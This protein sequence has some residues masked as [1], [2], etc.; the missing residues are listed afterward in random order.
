MLVRRDGSELPI[1]DSVAPIR[2]DDGRLSGIVL[3][4]RD[5]SE[6]RRGERERERLAAELHDRYSE[7]EAVYRTAAIA[8]ALIDP[9]EFRYL[10]VNDRLCAMLNTPAEQLVGSKVSELAG[11]VPDLF[12]ALASAAKGVPVTGLLLEG[13]LADDPETTRTWISDYFPVCSPDGT[14]LAISAASAEITAVKQA[15]AANIGQLV[16]PPPN[17]VRFQ[18]AR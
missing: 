3:V 1:D 17:A 15:E 2:N 6:K 12:D 10:R 4:F 16:A 13:V 14:V 8:M 7:I 5:V 18:K 11:N 9:V